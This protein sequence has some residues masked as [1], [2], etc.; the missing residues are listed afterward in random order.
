MERASAIDCSANQAW[1]PCLTLVAA[2]SRLF[3]TYYD[4]GRV[5]TLQ[6][7][8]GY[9]RM[10]WSGCAGF[11]RS[12]WLGLFAS[13]ELMLEMAGADAVRLHVRAGGKS[14]DFA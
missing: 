13:C 5:E 9:V 3:S 11:N 12:I 2:S 10:R 6:A 7:R 1:L 4:T 14:E 8:T